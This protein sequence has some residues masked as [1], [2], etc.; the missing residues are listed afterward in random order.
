MPFEGQFLNPTGRKRSKE[1]PTFNLPEITVTAQ[2]PKPPPVDLIPAKGGVAASFT[3]TN[4]IGEAPPASQFSET[5]LAN[6]GTV[7]RQRVMEALAAGDI[8]TENIG[9]GNQFGNSQLAQILFGL[10]EAT[11]P[12]TGHPIEA[13]ASAGKQYSRNKIFSTAFENA[14]AGKSFADINLQGLSPDEINVITE[15]RQKSSEQELKNLDLELGFLE[16]I[17]KLKSEGVQTDLLEEQLE[18]FRD[19]RTQGPA[20]QQLEQRE[21]RTHEREMI[22]LQANVSKE[23]EGIRTSNRRGELLYAQQLQ[24]PSPSQ[25]VSEMINDVFKQAIDVTIQGAEDYASEDGFSADFLSILT[26]LSRARG[27]PDEYI[28]KFLV[29]MYNA[30]TAKTGGNTALTPRS[31][32]DKNAAFKALQDSVNTP[33]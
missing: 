8:D 4:T 13:I 15:A 24:T 26:T 10:G 32:A 33:F 21:Q 25:Q 5:D 7:T 14:L 23:L 6:S 27:L 12:G 22:N 11:L 3:P 31:D 19:Q 1:L 9:A 2:L 20:L 28:N 30:A 18:S 29:P 17:S 16:R